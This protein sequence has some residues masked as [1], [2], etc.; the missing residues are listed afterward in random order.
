MDALRKVHAAPAECQ[1]LAPPV[2]IQ[3]AIRLN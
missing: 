1:K 3:R 2:R